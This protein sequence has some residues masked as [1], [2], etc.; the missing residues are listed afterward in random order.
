[1][2]FG[3]NR[4]QFKNFKWRFYTTR[5]FN[6]YFSQNGLELGKYVAQTAE[7]ELPSME[8]FMEFTFRQKVN[9]VVYN[10]F[11]EF[12]QSNVGIGIDW[13]NTG[14]VTKLLVI[15]CW[16]ISTGTMKICAARS[17]RVLPA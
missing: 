11:G 15:N 5:H 8:E 7:K 16:F 9:I 4:V 10:N 13:Q 2:E 3:Q 6:T 1:M 12:K 14:G 17:A